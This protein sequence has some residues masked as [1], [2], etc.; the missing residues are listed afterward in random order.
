M[1]ALPG[2][3]AVRA[4]ESRVTA[5]SIEIAGHSALQTAEREAAL[6]AEQKAERDARYA[7]PKAAKKERRRGY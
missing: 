2:T 4:E 6:K 3:Q 7:A 5:K 1:S